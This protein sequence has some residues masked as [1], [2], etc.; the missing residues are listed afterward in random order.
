MRFHRLSIA[1]F[2]PF[3]GEE[4]IDFDRLGSAGLFLLSGPTGAGKT[5]ILDALCYALFGETTGEGQAKGQ[6][7][8]RS[9]AELRCS[10]SA[11]EQKT[12]VDL[13]FSVG[14][15]TYRC[16]RNPEYERAALR[17]AGVTRELAKAVLY[18]RTGEPA[19]SPGAW[20]PIATKVRDVTERVHDI[21]GFSA[22]Q[23]RRVIVIPQGRFRDVLVASGEA[24]EA[25][26][27]RIF[28]T[29][30]YE[31]FESLVA[32]RR[33][34]AQVA[35]EAIHREREALLHGHDWAAGLDD[36][37]VTAVLQEQIA[38]ATESAAVAAAGLADVARRHAAATEALGQAREIE[39][40]AKGVT[41][42]RARDRRAQDEL[43][44]RAPDRAVL[45]AAAEA[46][47]PARLLREWRAL[48]TQQATAE[49]RQRECD[50]AATAAAEVV[51]A[52]ATAF[53]AAERA[54]AR[55]MAIDQR[56]GQIAT[57]LADATLVRERVDA[58]GQT[59]TA[60]EAREALAIE[61][62]RTAAAAACAA[63]DTLQQ[64]EVDVADATGRYLAGTAARLA[65]G[66]ADHAACP[67]CGSTEHP[68]PAEPT[69]EAP[70][71]AA[72]EALRRRQSAARAAGAA[73]TQAAATTQA[74]L[75]A[76]E[77]ATKAARAALTAMPAAPDVKGL[78]EERGTLEKSRAALDRDVRATRRE[79]E[80]ARAAAQRADEERAA[81]RG[82]A[83]LLA[84][85]AA[86]ARERF[87][88][89]L[90][91]S[92][93]ASV[94]DLRAADRDPA[95]IESLTAAV[96]AADREAVAAADALAAAVAALDGRPEPDVAAV[97]AAQQQLTGAVE[98]ARAEDE[99][100]RTLLQESRGLADRHADVATRSAAADAAF[101][102]SY[103]LHQMVSG[104]AH[105]EDKVSLH[106]WV[107]GAVLEEVVAEATELLR[108]MT[109]GRYELLRAASGADRKS[110]AGLD[111]DVLDAWNGTR[112]PARTLS[113]GETFMASLALSLALA[114]T[115]ERHQGGRRL[116]TV[117]IDEGFGSLDAETLEYALATLAS[118][119]DEGRV[120][121]VIS[122]VD[123]MQRAIPAQLRI[124]RQGETVRTEIVGI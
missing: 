48:A 112:R 82:A 108:T 18:R 17:G 57:R 121:G 76:A 93:F 77:A 12:K 60:A 103:R 10:R 83:G 35:R 14:G 54:A 59:V 65:A 46:R 20:E 2:G 95:T 44:R 45:A 96:A 98:R 47:E 91:A 29:D 92:P 31:R 72:L 36:A 80:E 4:V 88:A 63:A 33:S 28:G 30:A 21:T 5:T 11:P 55:T 9:G 13:T 52:R 24:R 75:A 56:L 104:M 119:R 113:G 99:A 115:A 117:F 39:R 78:E 81:A 101:Q 97:E 19:E 26:L 41:M 51:A 58:A 120:V 32:A 110:L 53:G 50:Q 86:A 27:K 71:E 66:L 61:A 34:D 69:V 107:L 116:E 6:I 64:V 90:A 15:G 85:K 124:V 1:G 89:A 16:E 40:L 79:L 84:E 3:A 118:L 49:A 67:V 106:R 25:L 100:A 68:R 109:R 37:A 74:A 38:A 102:T 122:H 73:A 123:E 114:R 7:D 43:A 62:S 22:E 105:A 94:D 111:I 42:A 23:F 70:T 8:G 87:D